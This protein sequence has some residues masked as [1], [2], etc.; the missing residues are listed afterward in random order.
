MLKRLNC[1]CKPFKSSIKHLKTR[2]NKSC[3][4]MSLENSIQAICNKRVGNTEA[5]NIFLVYYAVRSHRIV[6]LCIGN[7]WCH[8]GAVCPHF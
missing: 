3:F 2:R 7:E 4:E 6:Y 8:C 5:K 1:V